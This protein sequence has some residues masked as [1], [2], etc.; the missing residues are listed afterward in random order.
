MAGGLAGKGRDEDMKE[1]VKK[2]REARGNSYSP[3]SSFAVGAAVRT[4]SGRV[5]QGCN[6]ENCSYGLTVCAER[7]AVFNAVSEGECDLEA[8]AIFTEADDLTPPCGA[9]RQV[10]AEFSEELVIILANPK[11]ERELRLSEL[12]PM[13]FNK[14]SL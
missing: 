12:L 2:A 1:L 10:L 8:L 6:I 14:H 11:G 7:V 3:Y 9:C 13:P 4:K 5:F